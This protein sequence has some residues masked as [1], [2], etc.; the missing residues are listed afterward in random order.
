MKMIK[1]RLFSKRKPIRK[2]SELSTNYVKRTSTIQLRTKSI[3]TIKLK[4]EDIKSF[5]DLDYFN[6]YD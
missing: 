1:K 2:F 5:Y 4:Q 6:I 3:S